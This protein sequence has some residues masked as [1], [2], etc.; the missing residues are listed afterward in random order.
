MKK[1]RI[2]FHN[3]TGSVSKPEETQFSL[4]TN[5]ELEAFRIQ[6]RE[7]E[8]K[9]NNLFI[10]YTHRYKKYMFSLSEAAQ[11]L[12]ITEVHL[13]ALQAHGEI[14]GRKSGK[15]YRFYAG[16]IQRFLQTCIRRM[17]R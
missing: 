17:A 7:P 10:K 8:S 9:I 2:I 1:N 11:L 3:E 13:K 6:I 16:D 4:F 14:I 5:T 15:K 12:G